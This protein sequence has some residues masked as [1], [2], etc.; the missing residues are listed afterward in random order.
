MAA[1]QTGTGKT[2]GFTLPI[3]G[4]FIKGS[5]GSRQSGARFNSYPT[6]ELAAQIQ[7]SIL[8]YGRHLP[9]SSAVVFG[10]VKVNLSNAADV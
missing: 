3:F 5:K 7:E 9:L 6:R 10:G 1:A 2:A 4:A 8:V